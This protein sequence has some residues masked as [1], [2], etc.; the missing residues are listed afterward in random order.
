MGIKEFNPTSPG[1]RQMTRL[2]FSELTKKAPEKSLM[3]RHLRTGGRNNTGRMTLRFRG[4]GVKRAY[5]LIDFKRD[6]FGVPGRVTA[7]EYDPNRTSFIALIQYRDGEKRYILAPADL[8]VGDEV[9]SADSAEIKSGNCLRLSSIPVGALIHNLELK[10]N[11]GGQLVRSAGM[12]AQLV[13]KEE[14]YA[15]VRLPSGEIRKI[16][17]TCKAT[18]G[19]VGNLAHENIVVGKAGRTRYRGFRPHVRGTAMN[20]VD[21]PHGGGEGRTKGGRHPVSPEGLLAKG[22]KTRNHPATDKYI[23]QRRK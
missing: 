1:M 12:S 14:I 7:I 11:H 4:G 8:K 21:H 20:P 23:L 17:L 22:K 2:D 16:L 19:Q 3:E 6:K 18:I 15:S 5:R 13:G 10:P 9:I